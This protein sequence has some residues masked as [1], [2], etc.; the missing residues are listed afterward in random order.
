MDPN[1]LFR[2]VFGQRV[3]EL[4]ETYKDE[5][6]FYRPDVGNTFLTFR[7]VAGSIPPYLTALEPGGKV[8]SLRL[9]TEFMGFGPMW[10]FAFLSRGMRP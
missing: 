3:R 6:S 5:D 10:C 8:H 9:R 1:I 2:A 7:R 4:L